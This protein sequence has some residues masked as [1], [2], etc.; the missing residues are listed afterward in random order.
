MLNSKVLNHNPTKK[1][2]PKFNFIREEIAEVHV[3]VTY[4]PTDEQPADLLTKA[5]PF[6]QHNA[7]IERI[8]CCQDP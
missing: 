4:V 3:Q 5:L 8:M 1:I 2:S 6:K 7:H